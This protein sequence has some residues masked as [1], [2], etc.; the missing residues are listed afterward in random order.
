MDKPMA[1]DFLS[2]IIAHKKE[3]VALAKRKTP[4]KDLR[5]KAE[6]I[7]PRRG[8]L[9]A[10][11]QN[12]GQKKIHIIAEVKRASPS[13]GPIC[14]DLNPARLAKAYEKGGAACISVL[15]DET[16]FKGSLDD[17]KTVRRV[18]SL[19]VLR[20]EFIL[21]EYQV[22]ESA[23][24]GA[25]ALL[26][27]VRILAPSQLEELLGLTNSLGLDA[28]VEVYSREELER[29]NAVSARLIG[30]NNRNLKSFDTDIAHAMRLFGQL[31][32]DQVGVA[33]SGIAGPKDVAVNVEQGV[34][35][36]LIGESLVR[37][38]DPEAFLKQLYQAG[39]I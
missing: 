14:L 36:F 16:F 30:I 9:S 11:E 13:K 4:L 3:E 25:D 28:L 12:D 10:L 19:P 2:R 24:A 21:S 1:E 18:T 22:Y 33:A 8:F 5:Q 35:N 6:D 38:A 31:D 26:L 37:S 39:K 20:K 32:H 7:G 34:K 27:I 15:T 23:A 17:M 29:A